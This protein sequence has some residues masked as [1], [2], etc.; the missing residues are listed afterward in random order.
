M[1][2]ISQAILDGF[3][4]GDREAFRC[5]IEHYQ[6][7]IYRLSMRMLAR[8]AEAEDLTQD[9]FIRAWEKRALYDPQRPL[10]PWLYRMTVNLSRVRFR[11]QKT[12]EIL[13]GTELPEI[14]VAPQAE[15]ALLESEQQQK[16]RESLLALPPQYRVCLALRLES[17]LSLEEIARIT[18]S[19][20]GTVKSR[21]NRGLRKY[22]EIYRAWEEKLLWNAEKAVS[23]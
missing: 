22:L 18:G 8:Q 13:L 10:E 5:I 7:K 11:R 21:L 19:P 9:V 6:R 23:S 16:V 14:E 1:E 17:G 3:H 2:T 12:R 4:N 20:L 15:L